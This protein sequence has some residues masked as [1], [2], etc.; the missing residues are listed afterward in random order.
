MTSGADGVPGRPG[1]SVPPRA[2]GDAP[3]HGEDGEDGGDG[4]AASDV[5]ARLLWHADG[6]VA[7]RCAVDGRARVEEVLAVAD[8][9]AG[10]F[11][12]AA[13]GQGGKGGNGGSGR[14]GREG[15]KGADASAVE[16]GK[17]GAPGEDGG[18]GGKGGRGGS[19]G[20]GGN[21]TITVGAEDTDLLMLLRTFPIVKGGD[22][23]IA[24]VGGQGGRGG[25]GGRGGNSYTAVE[26]VAGS[27]ENSK[28]K[29]VKRFVEGG[30]DGPSGV[31]GVTGTDG[32]VGMAGTPGSFRVCVDG[33]QTTYPWRYEMEICHDTVEICDEMGYGVLEPGARLLVSYAVKNIGGMP[34]PAFQ[35]VVATVAVSD[36]L[37]P[38][39]EPDAKGYGAVALQRSLVP[40][41]TPFALPAPVHVLLC[42]NEQPSIGAPLRRKVVVEHSLRVTRVEKELIS[43]ERT[44]IDVGFPLELSPVYGQTCA[45][46]GG[47]AVVAVD[48]RNVSKQAIGL[49]APMERCVQTRHLGIDFSGA[50][51]RHGLRASSLNEVGHVSGATV[52]MPSAFKISPLEEGPGPANLLFVD[53]SPGLARPMAVL[54]PG[55]TRTVA[56]CVRMDFPPVGDVVEETVA[57]MGGRCA[58]VPVSKGD[59]YGQ[60]VVNTV[61]D[62]GHPREP[63]ALRSIQI[64]PFQVQ[65]AEPFNYVAG[66]S[67]VLLVVN[68]RTTPKEIADWKLLCARLWVEE[69]C[70]AIWNT[71]LYGGFSLKHTIET[72]GRESCLAELF[73]HEDCVVVFLNNLCA[74]TGVRSTEEEEECPALFLQQ[75]ELL[76]ACRDYGLRVYIFGSQTGQDLE[77]RIR[78][79]VDAAD[80]VEFEDES[81]LLN[82]AASVLRPSAHI[83]CPEGAHKEDSTTPPPPRASWMRSEVKGYLWKLSNG[84]GRKT[85][86]LFCLRS[87][88]LMYYTRPDARHPKN[89]F[90][91]AQCS[92]VSS[93]SGLDAGEKEA[94][95]LCLETA[96]RVLKLMAIPDKK[97]GVSGPSLA[98]WQSAIETGIARANGAELSQTNV[99]ERAGIEGSA[100][101]CSMDVFSRQ[102]VASLKERSENLGAKLQATYPELQTLVVYENGGS[103]LLGRAGSGFNRRRVGEIQV[104]A[105]LSLY[106]GNVVTS[107][108]TTMKDDSPASVVVHEQVSSERNHYGL[109][110]SLSFQRKIQ[111]LQTSAQDGSLG[112]GDQI[113]DT[114]S[115]SLLVDAICSDLADENAA[116]RFGTV[117]AVDKIANTFLLKKRRSEAM[118]WGERLKHL[119]RLADVS[120]FGSVEANTFKFDELFRLLATCRLLASRSL[121]VYE[122]AVKVSRA[123]VIARASSGLLDIFALN[124]ACAVGVEKVGMLRNRDGMSIE[125]LVA[126]MTKTGLSAASNVDH[127]GG[128]IGRRDVLALMRCQRGVGVFGSDRDRGVVTPL[129]LSKES[130]D[131]TKSRAMSSSPP[132]LSHEREA[133][134][135]EED[136]GSAMQNALSKLMAE[137][138]HLGDGE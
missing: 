24:G 79:P 22:G 87:G 46:A 58:D 69:A 124:L 117:G 55:C 23:G 121:L 34:T 4:A 84:G 62:F 9:R 123:G 42:N 67:K 88:E 66:K 104:H 36:D 19:G 111:L 41:A 103:R 45:V 20:R 134:I 18:D 54:D 39:P 56:C 95:V 108:D 125:K 131:E 75:Q 10:V 16:N 127:K 31:D 136:Q 76:H 133:G 96:E 44:E 107:W 70:V 116:F 53:S 52:L 115:L 137:H 60:A 35:D 73:G 26:T 68:N 119:S 91:L 102:T 38:L 77:A 114:R 120:S 15:R 12:E 43:E 135:S 106:G 81:V 93:G 3:P 105:G 29:T 61:L 112:P 57:D 118:E 101:A 1:A 63:E 8:D 72:G 32:W 49:G 109:L 100:F 37:C 110:K 40:S 27:G 5:A 113:S 128:R 99:P 78:V 80:V 92:I 122:T 6:S 130:F 82:N 59:V 65:L 48:V 25:L 74:P 30:N 132:V 64:Q 71:G 85:K 90:P 33:Q 21:V 98:E 7:L 2:T 97:D 51:D 89:V 129:V 83:P 50:E 11:F 86:R 94:N 126:A 47:Y 13:G 28:E 17:D 138:G 14:E